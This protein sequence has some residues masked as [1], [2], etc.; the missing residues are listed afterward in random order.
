MSQN[1]LLLLFFVIQLIGLYFVSRQTIKE[2]FIF[3]RKFLPNGAAFTIITILFLPG[4]ALHEMAHFITALIL[5]L[6][7]REISI[8]PEF[9]KD[10]IKLGKVIYEKKDIFRGILVGVAPI[11]FGLLIF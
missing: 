7:V 5:F 3:L 9:Q 11:F 10:Q 8:L 2:L 4:T 6:H 1:S